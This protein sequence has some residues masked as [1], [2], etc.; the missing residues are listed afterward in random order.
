MSLRPHVS[1]IGIGTDD[2][3]RSVAF[4]EALGWHRSSASTE[5]MIFLRLANIAIGLH[6][7]V[8]LA[9]D[10]NVPATGE[11]FR[12]I[13]FAHNLASHEEVDRA[14]QTVLAAGGRIVKE[15]AETHWGG[16]SGYFADPD[17]NLWEIAHNPFIELADDG[18]M[19]LPD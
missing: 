3:A 14:F 6:P 5:N 15:A 16:Y 2:L 7:R 9:A 12:A 4:Y 18:T 1:M 8:M 19:R 17:G 13:T 10:A 11:S